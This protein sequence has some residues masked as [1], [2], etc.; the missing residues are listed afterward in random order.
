MEKKN[1]DIK[2]P[3]HLETVLI[4][5]YTHNLFRVKIPPETQVLM[6]AWLAQSREKRKLWKNRKNSLILRNAWKV[7]YEK[8]DVKTNPE[9]GDRNE[10][11]ISKEKILEIV[12]QNKL[13]LSIK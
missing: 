2:M 11:I 3:L 6:T 7:L 8:A 4:Q 5:V 1:K 9:I 13:E 12:N 10:H